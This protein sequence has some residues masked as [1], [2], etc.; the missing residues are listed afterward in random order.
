MDLSGNHSFHK[1]GTLI[2]HMLVWLAFITYRFIDVNQ[3]QQL[4]LWRCDPTDSNFSPLISS[5]CS[6]GSSEVYAKGT[7]ASPSWIA[8]A[9]STGHCSLHD[10]RSGEVIAS[11]Q[12]HDGYVTKVCSVLQIKN[13]LKCSFLKETSNLAASCCCRPSACFQLSWQN[14]AHLGS[15]KVVS[16]FILISML[17][18]NAFPVLITLIQCFSSLF[19]YK[20][21]LL[22]RKMLLNGHTPTLWM[23]PLWLIDE[24]EYSWHINCSMS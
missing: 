8:A 16:F 22:A 9:C 6:S 10:M 5:I 11:W 24:N 12:A 14:L 21:L 1:E 3:G 18:I 15:Q 19:D 4:H 23:L 2:M 17:V 13:L 20:L 7:I